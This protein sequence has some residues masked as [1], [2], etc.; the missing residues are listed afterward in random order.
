ML[1]IGIDALALYPGRLMVDAPALAHRLG[2]DP[3]EVARRI[4]V[5]TRSVYPPCE[6]AVTLAVNAVKRL[7]LTE[8]ELVSIELLVVGTESAVDFG[9]PVASWVHRFAGLSPNCR[10]F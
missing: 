7:N 9:K 4:M 3:E 6:D 10:S 2:H 5:Q 8:E 1:D